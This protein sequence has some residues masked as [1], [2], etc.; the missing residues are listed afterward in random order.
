MYS[1][2]HRGDFFKY[3]VNGKE[4]LTMLNVL[5]QRGPTHDYLNFF[6][7]EHRDKRLVPPEQ[8]DGEL[9]RL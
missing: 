6:C 2:S 7:L 8:R 4:F 9:H 3:K 5:G 1:E